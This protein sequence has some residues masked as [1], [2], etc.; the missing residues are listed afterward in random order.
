M[1]NR[2]LV[3]VAAIIAITGGYL[4]LQSDDQCRNAEVQIQV[5][6]EQYF[7][8]TTA[9]ATA[10]KE[11]LVTQMAN[12]EN[13]LD[14]YEGLIEGDDE[15]FA[16]VEPELESNFTDKY[17]ELHLKAYDTRVSYESYVKQQLFDEANAVKSDGDYDFDV[18]RRELVGAIFIKEMVKQGVVPSGRDEYLL[19]L[20]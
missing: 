13:R 3:L 14:L 1:R 17:L 20:K 2:I 15:F 6:E 4:G 19:L 16:L 7:C 8:G 9:E 5:Y 12:F 11:E 10:F 18:N